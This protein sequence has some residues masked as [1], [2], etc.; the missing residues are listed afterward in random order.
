ML[1]ST[2]TKRRLGALAAVCLLSVALPAAPAMAQ[3]T[4]TKPAQVEATQPDPAPELSVEIASIDAVDSNVDEA[5]LRAIFSGSLL[6]NADALAGLTATSITIPEITLKASVTSDGTATDS[7][8]IWHDIVLN[9]VTDGVAA[10]VTMAGT[11]ISSSADAS[12]EFGALSANHVDIGGLLSLYGLVD[13]G[14]Q[15]EMQTLYTDFSFAGGA[16]TA[17]DLSCTF[18]AVTAAEFKGRPLGTSFVEIMAL[19]EALDAPTDDPSPE[20]IG[21]AMHV[22]ADILTAYESSPIQF[23]GFNCT[24]TDEDDNPVEVSVASMSMGGMSPGIYPAVDVTGLDFVVGS[25]GAVSIGA[26]SFKPIDLSAPIAALKSAP[27]AIDDAWFAAN[28][29]ALIPAFGGFSISDVA[30]DVPDPDSESG[31]IVAGIGN[32]D[33]ALSDYINGIPAALHASARNIMLE[34][35]ADSTDEQLQTLM[36]LGLSSIDA[37]FT[38]DANWDKASNTIAINEIS[39]TGVD[40]ATVTLAGTINN[41]TDALFS[42]NETMM[43]AAGMGLALGDLKLDVKDAGLSDLIMTMVAADQGSDAATLR[44]VFAGLAEGSIL[45][46]LAG[47]AEAQKV[48]TAVSDFVSGKAKNLTLNVK[49]KQQPGL[50]MFDFMAAEDN[51]AALLGK[52]TI[53][54]TN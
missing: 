17:P 19:F 28:A 51:P 11:T 20:L 43:L 21:K 16:F 33:L 8:V 18:G 10:S 15:T 26:M 39:A 38:I 36:A 31:R 22:Y 53:D 54:A 44:P 3:K 40:L 13:G 32:I 24:G 52:V 35:P 42:T 46:L 23:D 27:D 7:T 5:T 14:G 34:L 30:I 37:G 48:G 2:S 45:G 4:K 49:A 41:A 47:A 6:D 25:D 1:P 12:G 29:R 9:D 50:G